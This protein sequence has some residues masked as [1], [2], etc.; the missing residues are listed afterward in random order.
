[1][2]FPRRYSIIERLLGKVPK[3]YRLTCQDCDYKE[4]LLTCASFED[5]PYEDGGSGSRSVRKLP[6]ACPKCGG[7][8]LNRSKSPLPRS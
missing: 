6:K 5:K 7:T 2:V 1:M 4:Y 8:H 3:A